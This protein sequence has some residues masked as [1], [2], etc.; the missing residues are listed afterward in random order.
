MAVDVGNHKYIPPPA[1]HAESVSRP[2]C[3]YT[4]MAAASSELGAPTWGQY[5]AHGVQVP[6]EDADI[7][8]AW[9]ARTSDLFGLAC[10]TTSAACGQFIRRYGGMKAV[11]S[12]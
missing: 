7:R 12:V 2:T 1:K 11:M 4:A 8:G 6:R 9:C 10:D 5:L 3:L